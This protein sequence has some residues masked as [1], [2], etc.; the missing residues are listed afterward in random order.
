MVHGASQVLLVLFAGMCLCWTHPPLS[1]SGVS[2]PRPPQPTNQS[3]SGEVGLFDDGAVDVFRSSVSLWDRCGTPRPCSSETVVPKGDA[4]SST[5][6]QSPALP[7]S[8]P[9]LGTG[10]SDDHHQYA[11]NPPSHTSVLTH[12]NVLAVMMG[13]LPEK[14]RQ[15][16]QTFQEEHACPVLARCPRTCVLFPALAFLRWSVHFRSQPAGNT[17]IASGD[18]MRSCST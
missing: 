4:V 18:G 16:L 15:G 10:A 17:W 11:L 14:A 3:E 9:I 5:H 2:R 12:W 8:G 13:H 1:P 6:H 7:C